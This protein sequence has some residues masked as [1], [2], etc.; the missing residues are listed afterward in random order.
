M[1]EEAAGQDDDDEIFVYMGGDQRVPGRVKRA[2]I[3]EDVKIIRAGAFH[4]RRRLIYLE[5]HD[6]VEI[7]EKDAFSGCRS[8]KVAVKLLGVKIVKQYAFWGCESMPAVEFGDKLEEI[9]DDAFQRC[10]AL[11]SIKISSVRT[12]GKEAFGFCGELTDVEFGEALGTLKEAAFRGCPKLKRIALPLKG[13]MIEDDVFEDCPKLTTVDLVGGIHRTVASLHDESWR[14]DMN[15]E[16]NR[17]NQIQ[18]TSAWHKTGEIDGINVYSRRT[19][20]RMKSVEI[21]QWMRST[22][23]CLDH[24]KEEHRNLLKEATTLLELALWKAS[25]SDNM[26]REGRGVITGEVETSRDEIRYTSGAD[27]VIKNVLPF[28]A[29][30]L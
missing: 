18:P 4:F 15:N 11:T 8:L 2:R 13:N 26:V 30:K 3:H 23:S 20:K 28:L 17:I 21:C 1:M 24:Y 6:G 5:I 10:T 14:S 12:I 19:V 16:I 27:I 9:G 25:L 22:I 7:I 29:L